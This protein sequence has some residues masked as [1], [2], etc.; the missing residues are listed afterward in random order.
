M[1]VNEE[2]ATL[3]LEACFGAQ[4]CRQEEAEIL[5]TRTAFSTHPHEAEWLAVV[6]WHSATITTMHSSLSFSSHTLLSDIVPPTETL[7]LS[8]SCRAAKKGH[9]VQ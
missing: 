3:T 1:A 9:Q 6:L 7:S 8:A 5:L 4:G 2:L